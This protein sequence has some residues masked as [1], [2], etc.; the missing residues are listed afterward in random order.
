MLEKLFSTSFLT[1]WSMMKKYFHF[2]MKTKRIKNI[3][4][5]E[6]DGRDFSNGFADRLR[7]IVSA[8]AYSKASGREYQINH[9]VPFKLEDYLVPNKYNWLPDHSSYSFNLLQ[10]RPIA[11]IDYSV[12]KRLNRLKNRFQYHFYTNVDFI[13][14]VN[15]KYSKDYSYHDLYNELFQPGK[16]LLDSINN[17]QHY[18]D[19][20][21]ISVSFRFMQ[22][23][24]D[25][26]D[27]RGKTLTDKEQ[28]ELAL[29]CVKQVES[30]HQRHPDIP[31]VLV[32]SDSSKFISYIKDLDYVFTVD[33]PIGHVG[34]NGNDETV[35]KTLLDYYMIS[36]ARKVYM[37]Y[38]GEMYKSNFAKAAAMSTGADYEAVTF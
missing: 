28:K 31:Y 12:P 37:A 15:K 2:S 36:K 38:T 34:H 33:G 3:V 13:G 35:K 1:E 30:L 14:W 8:Y 29:R 23:M 20:G 10:S 16:V 11:I 19:K 18:I 24:G 9:S 26:K 4:V 17:Y 7:G 21:Y 22:L 5:Y 27:V 32:T 25:F 6:M